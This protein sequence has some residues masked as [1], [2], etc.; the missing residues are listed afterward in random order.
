MEP[1]SDTRI[2]TA[3]DKGHWIAEAESVIDRGGVV[4]MATETVYGLAGDARSN[5]A[6]AAIYAA[7]GRPSR[8]PL[9]VHVADLGAARRLGAFNTQALALAEEHWPGPL[10]LV[11]PLNPDAELAKAVTAGGDSIALRSPRGAIGAFCQ[12]TRRPVAAP[13]A[14]L[15]GHV[16]A[17]TA[18]H[19]LADLKGRIPLIIDSGPCAQGVES[20]I[21]DARTDQLQVLRPG[22][23]SISG[24]STAALETDGESPVAP[25]MMSR[26]YAPATPLRIDVLPTD[27]PDGHIYLGF[28]ATSLAGHPTLSASGDLAEAAQ[29]LFDALR[30]ADAQGAPGIAVAPIPHTGIGAAI[31]NR[32]ARAAKGR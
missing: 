27:V 12:K 16:S 28:G 22:G 2:L 9:I 14:N 32:L 13:S 6:V 24:A 25:G 20:T 26:H 29:N 11:V 23:V 1:L 18:G 8:N 7:K 31:R 3:D 10:T 4:A 15:S 30:S 19:V 21:I 5:E 17:T